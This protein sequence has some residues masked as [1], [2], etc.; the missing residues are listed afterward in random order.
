MSVIDAGLSGSKLP[1]LILI[2]L[3]RKVTIMQKAA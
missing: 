2:K 1:K 3:K